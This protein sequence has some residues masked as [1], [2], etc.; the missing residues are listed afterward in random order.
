MKSL[1][2]LLLLFILTNSCTHKKNV[3]IPQCKNNFQYFLD[4]ANNS[5]L[6]ID[7]RLD[8]ANKAFNEIDS[9]KNNAIIRNHYLDLA[10]VYNILNDYKSSY[11]V[12]KIVSLKSKQAN[13]LLTI[14]HSEY[15]MGSLYYANSKYDSAYY[16]YNKS[17]KIFK[18]L[19]NDYYLAN[20]NIVKS[21]IL[22]LKNDYAASEA[23]S[24]K[25]LKIAKTLKDG[26]L[27]Y[28][29][30]I[31]LG[32]DLLGMNDLEKALVYYNKAIKTIIKLDDDPQ[33]PTHKAQAYNYISYAY[34]K[35]KDYKNA[36]LYAQKGLQF[37]DFK[38]V[39]PTLYCYLTN[40]LGYAQLKLHDPSCLAHFE[41]TLQIGK[42]IG[43]AIVQIISKMNQSE[44]FLAQKDT[45]KALTWMLDAKN[46]AKKHAFFEEELKAL[47]LLGKIEPKKEAFY[48]TL[49]SK[50]SDSL[51]VVER[52]TRDKFARIEF[53]TNEIS[54]EKKV[55]ETENKK[56]IQQV[57][58][59]SGISLAIVLLVLAL[60]Y[61]KNQ[62][63]KLKELEFEKEQQE[64]NSLINKL[65]L[66][67][68]QAMETGRNLEKQRISLEL[69]DDVMSKLA[70]VRLNLYALKYRQ[71]P[72]TIQNCLDQ[73]PEMQNI[74]ANIRAIT[75]D[76]VRADSNSPVSFAS[77]VQTF[78]DEKERQ[79]GI[80]FQL[81]MDEA[82]DWNKIN[83]TVTLTLYRIL[84]EAIQNIQKYAEANLVLVS[85]LEQNQ[86]I[87]MTIEDNGKGFDSN[88]SKKGIGLKN[89]NKRVVNLNGEIS[90]VSLVD[91]GTKINLA[92]PI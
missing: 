3:N 43:S 36:L 69:H 24:I 44:Y 55:V 92:I 2:S 22:N 10:D 1:I 56:L 59:I 30:Y 38:K 5:N 11:R 25:A 19:K 80:T 78:C 60:L 18:K 52:A 6:S 75:H 14:A 83:N 9:T 81:K 47:Q 74:E 27:I 73:L 76:L 39:N 53:E 35:K 51:Q 77:I 62:K 34:Q 12:Y 63:T 15:F 13:D 65:M 64:A 71:D 66:E 31:I 68:Q 29:C 49:Y 21:N 90:I 85:I 4:K 17:E 32:N 50:L 20:I 37:A 79:L 58:I 26:I 70:G 82:I 88:T 48:T 89:M 57:L 40:N 46:A 8:F 28:N 91:K 23:R 54:T 86:H 45:T 33:N 42:N 67:Q 61:I 84:Q 87:L 72:E 7:I 41:E 16:Y